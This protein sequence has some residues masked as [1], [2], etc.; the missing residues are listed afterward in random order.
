[1]SYVVEYYSSGN[2]HDYLR[3]KFDALASDII[4]ELGCDKDN[5][6]IDFG[7]GYGG[8]LNELYKRDYTNCYGTDISNWAI[9]YGRS[10]FQEVADR[11]Q[12]YNRNLL[13]LPK[14]HVLFL[15]VLEHMPEHEAISSLQLALENLSGYIICRIPIS[16]EEGKR[17]F[18][19][20]SNN[21]TTH[22]NCH[23][24]KWWLQTLEGVGFKF[25]GDIKR[26]TIYSSKGVLAGVWKTML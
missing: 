11:L 10:V 8:L 4:S 22:I 1:M 5:L 7:C 17:Y 3:R 25:V 6:I 18:L 24:R 26:K 16:V 13:S 12:Y 14:D 2:Y 23:C 19:E 20:V 15:D 9:E 21:D